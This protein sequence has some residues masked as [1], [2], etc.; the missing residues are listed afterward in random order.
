LAVT[1]TKAQKIFYRHYKF[2]E[3]GFR[4]SSQ[5]RCVAHLY[6]CLTAQQMRDSIF[7]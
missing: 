7:Y 5:H 1:P 4:I 3:P 6:G 2:Y